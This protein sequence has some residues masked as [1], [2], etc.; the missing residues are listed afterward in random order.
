MCSS[1]VP[2]WY[3][4]RD[5]GSLSQWEDS[6][7]GLEDSGRYFSLC[8]ERSFRLAIFP[9]GIWFQPLPAVCIIRPN[10]PDDGWHV[11]V[12][13][14]L[15][16]P[17]SPNPW[18]CGHTVNR[19]G[20]KS[21]YLTPVLTLTWVLIFLNRSLDFALAVPRGHITNHSNHILWP[22]T[23]KILLKYMDTFMHDSVCSTCLAFC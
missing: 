2:A 3:P 7:A 9:Q 1:L 4:A 20:S 19:L 11:P 14:G 18:W 8:Q 5:F 15:S 23:E 21:V 10:F 12:T 13:A 16:A 17:G 22:P 6:P